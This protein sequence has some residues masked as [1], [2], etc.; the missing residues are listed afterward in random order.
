[1]SDN[2]TAMKRI[3]I[4]TGGWLTFVSGVLLLP[5]PLPLPFPA[6]P[7]LV[8]IGCGILTPHSKTFRRGVQQLR[9]RYG[10]LSR[11]VDRLS[12]RA[13]RIVKSMVAQTS[14]LALERHA[15]LRAERAQA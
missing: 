3:L 13:P 2:G 10:W 5:V 15:R 6:G 8:L 9:F 12:Q 14:P 7:I 4:L 11:A 1:M